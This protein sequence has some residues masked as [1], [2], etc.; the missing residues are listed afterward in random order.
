M[1]QYESGTKHF[2]LVKIIKSLNFISIII[3]TVND[4]FRIFNLLSQ[5]VIEFIEEFT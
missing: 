3:L 5:K 4:I 1:R 2:F